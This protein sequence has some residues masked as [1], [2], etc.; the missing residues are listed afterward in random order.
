MRSYNRCFFGELTLYSVVA[1]TFTYF[2][3]TFAMGVFSPKVATYGFIVPG[4]VLSLTNVWG[5]T[6][7]NKEFEANLKDIYKKEHE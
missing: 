2:G 4:L 6:M 7:H 3:S 1:G 5:R